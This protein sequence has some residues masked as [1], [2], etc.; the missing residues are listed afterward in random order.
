MFSFVLGGVAKLASM[1]ANHKPCSTS[2]SNQC[3]SQASRWQSTTSYCCLLLTTVLWQLRHVLKIHNHGPSRPN[4]GLYLLGYRV[5]CWSPNPK[6]R[7][8]NMF[9]RIPTVLSI[10]PQTKKQ[11]GQKP[12]GPRASRGYDMGAHEVTHC[13]L[14]RFMQTLNPKP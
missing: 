7:Y 11:E 14:P 5:S 12:L 1:D 8:L 13:Q 2:S 10:P 4:G 3:L 6:G 9:P